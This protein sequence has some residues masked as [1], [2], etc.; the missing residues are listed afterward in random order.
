MLVP[1]KRLAVV[2]RTGS[3]K[4]QAAV[5]FL[6][7]QDFDA[8][9]WII[10]DF[11]RD[12]LIREINP[13]EIKIT[14]RIPDKPGLYVVRPGVNEKDGVEDFLW[15]V[16]RHE[17][18]GI[19][20]DEGYM[21]GDSEAFRALLTQGRSKNIPMIVLSQRPVWLSRFVWS[22]SD[23][24]VVFRLTANDDKK[25]IR[26]YFPLPDETLPAFH[27][28]FYDVAAD[29]TL[30]LKPV[31]DRDKIISKFKKDRRRRRIV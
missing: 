15:N 18:V 21:I 31:P 17:N 30:L 9:P 16:W 13:K 6:G 19:F 1:G 24:F 14:D 27:S 12:G 7:Q 4:T 25:T 26:G 2:G 3:G 22:E 20:L 23:Y 5:F 8:M 29:K 11:K 28:Y 10:I